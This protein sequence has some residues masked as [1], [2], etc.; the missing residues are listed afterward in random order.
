M[1]FP[2]STIIFFAILGCVAMTREPP[3]TR[4]T[5][6]LARASYGSPQAPAAYRPTLYSAGPTTHK[7]NV[8][9]VLSYAA[10]YLA[11]HPDIT[12]EQLEEE[13]KLQFPA[14]R[15]L[16]HLDTFFGDYID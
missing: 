10:K 3:M 8:D 11:S 9:V 12:E 2:L 16:P 4:E 1:K 15:N 13:V 6:K 5:P 7:P 14:K